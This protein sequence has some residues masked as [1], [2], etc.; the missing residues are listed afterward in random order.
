MTQRKFDV[1][2]VDPPWN[3]VYPRNAPRPPRAP[4]TKQGL[5]SLPIEQHGKDHSFLFLWCTNGK[6]KDT[7]EPII[8][9]AL[10]AASAWGYSFFTMMTW[11]KPCSEQKFGPFFVASEHCIF[12]YKG[13]VRFEKENLGKLETVITSTTGGAWTKPDCFYDAVDM[14]FS[15]EKAEVFSNH[16]RPNFT[17]IIL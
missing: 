6:D 12:A 16:H 2:V 14:L 15:G 11:H 8:R 7:G 4:I 3:Q 13:L 5:L 1:L 9:L 17:P 10:D